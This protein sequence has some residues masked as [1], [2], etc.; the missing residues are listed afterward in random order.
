MSTAITQAVLNYQDTGEG[1]EDLQRKITLYAYEFPYR[2]TDW[3]EDRCSDFF[4]EFYPRIPG[5]VRRFR[6]QFTFETYLASSLRWF[7]KTFIIHLAE[8]QY[9]ADWSE[10]ELLCRMDESIESIPDPQEEEVPW[11]PEAC[12]L[13]T[14]GK[15]RVANP[16]IRRRVLFTVLLHIA[17]IEA[18]CLPA[19]AALVGVEIDWLL[20]VVEEIREFIAD[21]LERREELRRRRNECWYKMEVAERRAEVE[22]PYDEVSR[23]T[24]EKRT[25]TWRSRY[26][27]AVQGI[28]QLRVRP[29]HN[30][31]AH[32]LKLPPGTV[33]SGI[34]MFK[35]YLRTLT[36][37]SS[38]SSGPSRHHRI[39]SGY[40]N[41][42][43]HRKSPQNG[44]ASTHT[45]PPFGVKPPGNRR[46]IRR[47]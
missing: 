12:P 23:L 44:G 9:H 4:L 29:T 31:I 35:Q 47:R 17:E 16:A 22:G 6:P 3:D 36:P 32:V 13:E 46:R 38:G 42:F 5:L 24:W 20:G 43:G 45:P 19:V 41:P 33:A 39:K 11:T 15:G 28:R 40:G 21:K 25:L 14:D 37:E 18:G 30:D 1:W 2:W 8:R 34:F 26:N 7:I 10:R 27:T